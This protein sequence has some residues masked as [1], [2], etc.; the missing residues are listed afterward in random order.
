[1]PMAITVV[2][3]RA[4]NGAPSTRAAPRDRARYTTDSGKLEI[5]S[6]ARE[7]LG[8][9]A[10]G[11]WLSVHVGEYVTVNPDRSNGASDS[12]IPAATEPALQVTDS[13]PG[14]DVAE[15]AEILV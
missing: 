6:S 11:N 8:F 4:E 12:Q 1:M 10:S 13:T 3:A 14:E 9:Y 5:I 7:A 15:D 2:T